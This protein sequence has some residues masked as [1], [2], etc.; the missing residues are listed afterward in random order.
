MI[1]EAQVGKAAG[2]HPGLV[3]NP[4]LA[5]ALR[6]YQERQVHGQLMWTRSGGDDWPL[7]RLCAW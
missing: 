6:A 2:D 7:D 4:R 1:E 3:T 5:E